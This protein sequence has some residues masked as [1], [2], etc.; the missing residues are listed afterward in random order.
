MQWWDD[1]VIPVGA[2]NPT[3]AYEWIN[4]T[5]E[6]KHQAQIDAW[7]SAVTPVAG[8]QADLP[9][10]RP[11]GREEPADLPAAQLHEELLDADLASGRPRG[12]APDRERVGGSDRILNTLR[13]R[14]SRG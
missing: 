1:W 12:R 4:Y 11:A 14:P 3:A 6:P 7:T 10:D 2:P 9:E 13:P 5:Y 8:R